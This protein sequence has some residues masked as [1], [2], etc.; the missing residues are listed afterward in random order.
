MFANATR[1]RRA[2]VSWS[3]AK[4]CLPPLHLIHLHRLHLTH[5][6]LHLFHPP[7]HLIHPSSA[8]PPLTLLH[9]FRLT[10]LPLPSAGSKQ[11]KV[12]T[13]TPDAIM[14]P[15]HIIPHKVLTQLHQ[16]AST[17]LLVLATVCTSPLL[18]KWQTEKADPVESLHFVSKCFGWLCSWT[19]ILSLRVKK[20]SCALHDVQWIVWLVPQPRWGPCLIKHNE[21]DQ[22]YK[23]QCLL[24]MHALTDF[25][26]SKKSQCPCPGRNKNAVFHFICKEAPDCHFANCLICSSNPVLLQS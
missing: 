3:L 14:P 24:S 12:A 16:L 17:L 22:H 11:P 9:L 10:D 25:V 5:P 8:N 15:H 7:L 1:H 2:Y 4:L 20:T 13:P 6:S 23:L 21:K 19:N 18:W 26:L